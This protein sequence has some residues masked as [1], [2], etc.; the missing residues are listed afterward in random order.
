MR[1]REAEK[2]GKHDARTASL[3]FAMAMP[4]R[5]WPWSAFQLLNCSPATFHP[6]EASVCMCVC[7]FPTSSLLPLCLPL[8]TCLFPPFRSVLC[9][10]VYPLRVAIPSHPIPSPSLN[11]LCPEQVFFFVASFLLSAHGPPPLSLCRL[12]TPPRQGNNEPFF[13]CSVLYPF[14]VDPSV[15]LL[16]PGIVWLVLSLHDN[17]S[18]CPWWSIA[19]N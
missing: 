11:P 7:V 3:T 12:P 2:E 5:W 17:Q 6:A 9:R 16:P 8:W 19:N 15:V 10:L 18:L 13:F 4:P 14:G 1:E